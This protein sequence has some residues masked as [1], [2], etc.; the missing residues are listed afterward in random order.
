VLLILKGYDKV[1]GAYPSLS[2]WDTEI[3]VGLLCIMFLFA[4]RKQTAYITR[5]VKANLGQETKAK[6]KAA[7]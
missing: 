2:K 4:Y 7:V 5:R 3:L 1:N 6:A